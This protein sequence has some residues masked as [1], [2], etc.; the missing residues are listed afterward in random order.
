MLK[1]L[2]T[3]RSHTDHAKFLAVAEHTGDYVAKVQV[4]DI[5]SPYS[6][7]P[8]KSV[9]SNRCSTSPRSPRR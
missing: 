6:Y 7:S 4:A 3:M 8:S 2:K 9:G 1:V 5:P